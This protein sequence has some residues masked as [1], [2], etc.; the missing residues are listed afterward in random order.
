MSCAP[1]SVTAELLVD[2]FKFYAWEFNYRKSVVS[3]RQGSAVSKLSKVEDDCWLNHYRLS[4]EDPF[5]TWY[6]VAH[7]VKGNQMKFIRNEFVRAHTLIAR[8]LCS[9]RGSDD[10]LPSSLDGDALLDALLEEGN[11]E[12]EKKN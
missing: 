12:Y 9:R 2:F 3:I 8:A 1:L 6:D 5:E 10:S 11:E 4:I 7:V